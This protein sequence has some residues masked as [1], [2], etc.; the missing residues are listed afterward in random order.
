LRGGKGKWFSGN[1]MFLTQ[2]RENVAQSCTLP[3]RRFAIG[4]AFKRRK[5]R[6]FQALQN[7]ILRYGRL[8]ICAT[9]MS[10][11]KNHTTTCFGGLSFRRGG[12]F[13]EP[14]LN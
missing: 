4:K 14:E 10:R 2:A 13:R 8:K 7:S 5:R 11:S 9:E 6:G 12:R 1:G 3:Y